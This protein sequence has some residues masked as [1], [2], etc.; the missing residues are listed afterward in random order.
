MTSDRGQD[1][2][3]DAVCDEICSTDARY[4]QSPVSTIY[5]GGGTPS[6]LSTTAIREILSAVNQTFDTGSVTEVTF[7]LNPE[8]VSSGYLSR[9]K[10][11]GITRPSVGVQSFN[12][13]D[14][15]FLGRVHDAAVAIEALNLI[16]K[17]QFNSW[18]LDLIFGLPDQ[19]LSR[20][21]DN[22]NK[23]VASS[24]PHISTYN[25]TI[26]PRTPLQNLVARGHVRPAED[27][28]VAEAYQMAMD[29]L[30]AAGYQHYEISSFGRDGHWAQH[31]QAYWQHAN[32]L[33]MGPSAHSF[34]LDAAGARRW[35]NVSNLKTYV[36]Q[37]SSECS[38]V[39]YREQ[40]TRKQLATE[41]VML[42]LRTSRGISVTG[43]RREFGFDLEDART[44]SLA[45]LKS[46]GLIEEKNGRV[47]LTVQGR[48]VCDSVTNRLLPD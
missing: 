28:A 12:D 15:K 20:W 46:A 31:N 16:R 44:D 43:L 14:L 41:R 8:D 38:P 17:A 40:L 35:H 1:Q 39:D 34:W 2:F 13:A 4:C 47:R 48:H 7:E 37:V 3:V 29:R 10:G 6:R 9:L 22:L 36:K 21:R 45:A 11:L 18:T 26:E 19:S 5:F 25:L 27:G 33:G 32:Y 23:A 30:S 24:A 42:G